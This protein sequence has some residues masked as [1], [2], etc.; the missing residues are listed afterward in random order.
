MRF[1]SEKY[2]EEHPGEGPE[3]KP[4]LIAPWAIRN[5]LWKHQPQTPE[6]ILRRLLS[7][8]LRDDYIEDPQGREIRSHHPIVHEVMTQDG[9]KRRS[10][11]YPIF[12]T[13]G[14]TI[15]QAFQLRRRAA[16]ADVSQLSLDFDSWN[17]NNV[18]D[19]SLVQ[20]DFDFNKDLEE[21]RLPT[22]YPEGLD[23]REFDDSEDDENE[24]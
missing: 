20:M 22:E 19:E 18:F 16:L 21:M 5:G 8:A 23:D 10:T 6:E 24:D 17:D 13:H 1:L 15:R 4:H 12:T 11:W 7:R 9:L 2:L 3:V 14:E